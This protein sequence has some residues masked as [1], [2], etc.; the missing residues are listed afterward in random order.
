MQRGEHNVEDELVFANHRGYVFHDSRGFE[1]GSEEELKTVQDFV[2]RK[3]R[4]K[5]LGDRLHAIWYGLFPLVST[6]VNSRGSLLRYCIP[7]D[8]DRPSLE[9]RHFHD[10]C[11]DKNG[12]SNRNFMNRD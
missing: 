8:N 9:V 3:S 7:M 10:I 4:E 5:R 11:P 6:V 1:A 12:M 2:R